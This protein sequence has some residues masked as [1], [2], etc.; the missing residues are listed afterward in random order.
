MLRN[1][2]AAW[3]DQLT[4]IPIDRLVHLSGVSARSIAAAV[5]R[6]DDLP[7]AVAVAPAATG[8]IAAFVAEVLDTLDIVAQQL[9]PGWL[10]EVDELDGPQGAAVAAIR[11]VAI[12]RARVAGYS[13]AFLADLAERALTGRPSRA[14]LRPEVRVAG[15]ARIVA[16]GFRRDRLVLAMPTETRYGEPST[17]DVV[18]AGSEWLADRGRLGVWLA[19]AGSPGPERI[20]TVHLSL[21]SHETDASSTP[22]TSGEATAPIGGPHPRSPIEAALE[23]VL[24]GQKWAVGRI[25]NGIYQPTFLRSPIRPD[26][27]WRAE[28]VVVEL[29]GL[30]HCRPERYDA[31]RVRDVQLQLDGYAVLR[32]TNARVKHD[33][34]AVAAQIEQLIR[35]RRHDLMKGQQGG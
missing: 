14:R 31:D 22:T 33:V 12:E 20:G 17:S 34:Q 13:S 8:S 27:L 16:A 9:L 29:D 10:P 24:A 2:E 5:A 32:F 21:V 7:A 15:L 6:F 4:R 11:A 23:A 18:V 3:H 28:R 35:T 30:E 25:W 1:G 26:L 19:G